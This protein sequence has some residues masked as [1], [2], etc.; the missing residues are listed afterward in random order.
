ME[1]V[2]DKVI[3][4]GGFFGLYAAV[5]CAKHGQRV[6]LLERESEPF[7]RATYINQ[8]RV[9]MG[10]HYPRSISTAKKSHKYFERFNNEFSASIL[11][12]FDQI[13]AI[14]SNFSWTDGRQFQK[15]CTNAE[16]YCSPINNDTFFNKNMVDATFLTKEYSFDAKILREILLKELNGAILNFGVEI[17]SI[18]NDGEV[19]LINTE[20]GTYKTKFVLNATY[21]SINQIQ[22]ML[23]YEPFKIK[24]ELCEIILCEVSENFK[25][26]GLTVMDGNF[27]SI[28][29]FGRT[30]LHSLTSVSFTPHLTSY[31]DFPTFTCQKGVKCAPE[32][33]ENCNTCL[34]KPSTA[35]PFMKALAQ[36]YIK[37]DY[38][39]RYHSSLFS[40]KPIL[41][42]SELDDSRPTV[43]RKMSD[44]PVFYSVL[45]GKINTI[46]DLEEILI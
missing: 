10:Y 12:S 28:M 6:L 27:F 46:Y 30:G 19:F 25:N 15:F 33:L 41:R 2:F 24:Y 23:G 16:I 34:H 35:F 20:G 26:F 3:I 14:S 29:P 40:M 38:Q 8:A 1:N 37:K 13:Y 17:K 4:G 32:Q 22:K 9:H 43:M 42:A 39:F 18:E 44:S 11:S 31:D 45:S 5:F 36:K 21:A 7:S